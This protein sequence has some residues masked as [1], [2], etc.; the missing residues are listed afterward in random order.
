MS[1]VDLN[2]V[3]LHVLQLLLR[4]LL[5]S[6]P[7]MPATAPTP[8]LPRISRKV[9][10]LNS[11][12]HQLIDLLLQTVHVSSRQVLVIL[13]EIEIDLVHYCFII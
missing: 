13:I 9:S 8:V 1:Q 7:M 5:V 3:G 12:S 2:Y 4:V 11:P 10:P 6:R